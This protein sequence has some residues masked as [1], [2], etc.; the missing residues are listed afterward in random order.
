V[1]GW[2]IA[3]KSQRLR[4]GW[5]TVRKSDLT[6][7][8]PSPSS[9]LVWLFVFLWMAGIFHFSSRSKPLSFLPD[10][11]SGRG[12]PADKAAHLAEYAGL[13][14]LLHRALSRGDKERGTPAPSQDSALPGLS[15]TSVPRKIIISA[16]PSL[17][18][19]AI[20][21]AYA[22]FDEIHHELVPGRGFE[23]SDIGYDATGI[24]AAMGLIW[25]KTQLQPRS[26]KQSCESEPIKSSVEVGP[27]KGTK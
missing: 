5:K 9:L 15:R 10:S 27:A 24:G 16:S 14:L 21:L 3:G 25:V 22:F 20:A 11:V 4:Q 6:L 17:I 23:W 26:F 7:A 8:L 18:V 1:R 2:S 13:V 19:L 12:I